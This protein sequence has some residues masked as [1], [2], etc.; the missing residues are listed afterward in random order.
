MGKA[1][2]LGLIFLTA[3]AS[4]GRAA[5]A[6]DAHLSG[7]QA[8]LDVGDAAQA[9][10]LVD[11]ALGEG[12]VSPLQRSRL[13]HN[14]GV[15]HQLLGAHQEALADFTA[16]LE[17]RALPAEERAQALLQRGF[18][19]DSLQRLGEATRDYSA[20]AA[21]KTTSAATALN[22]RANIYRRQ[23]RLVEARR[24]YLAALGMGNARPQFSYYGLGQIAEARHDKE[25]ARGFYARAVD[26]DPAYRLAAERLG[27][28]GGPSESVIADPGVLKLR[29]P[30]AA[31]LVLKPPP[32]TG[33]VV[34]RPPARPVSRKPASGPGLRP[35]LD[36]AVAKPGRAEVQ[37]GAWRSEAEA[38][39]GWNKAVTR[40]G[41]ALD[42]LAPHIVAA[43]LPGK[44]RY[45]RLRTATPDPA[46]LCASLRAAGQDCLRA[47]E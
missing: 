8:A 1:V 16:A 44:G 5:P 9:K 33:R 35:A 15:A 4:A 42:G 19:L 22:N 36:A 37:L 47:R 45:F 34:L 43:D 38:Q 26:A 21:L 3:L 6:T 28:L 24:D 46:A 25:A 14:R 23:N 12:A 11:T 13:L 39:A 20:A 10:R 40:S 30:R 41:G 2:C 7:A 29:P 27:E 31:G 17:G 18:L 32:S